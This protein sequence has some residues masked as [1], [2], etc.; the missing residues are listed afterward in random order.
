MR[1]RGL[2]LKDSNNVWMPQLLMYPSEQG[3]PVSPTMNQTLRARNI[4]YAQYLSE[5][6]YISEAWRSKVVADSILNALVFVC[7]RCPR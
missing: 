4:C 5:Q 2:G 7:R 1:A 6:V 3:W